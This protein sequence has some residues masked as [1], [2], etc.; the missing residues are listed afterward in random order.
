MGFQ[1]LK[2]KE[3]MVQLLHC[4]QAIWPSLFEST[5]AEGRTPFVAA[6]ARRYV[7]Y[8]WEAKSQVALATGPES[9][10]AGGVPLSLFRVGP[11]QVI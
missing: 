11:G 2:L 9:S 6:N 10:L 1:G 4:F 5:E 7:Y 3:V 8:R